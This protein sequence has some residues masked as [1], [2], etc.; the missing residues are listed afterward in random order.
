M[1]SS[2]L[3]PDPEQLRISIRE[4]AYP[5][6]Q[7]EKDAVTAVDRAVFD[8]VRVYEDHIV[9]AA[10]AFLDEQSVHLMAAEEICEQLPEQ[11]TYALDKRGATADAATAGR[12]KDLRSAAYS[13]IDA[14]R[15]SER[16]AAWHQAKAEDPYG[17]YVDMTRKYPMLRP[18]I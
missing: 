14:L 2:A 3:S 1:S 5:N 18:S 12:L 13:A 6:T 17:S 11:V 16:E 7:S 10:E 9:A 4:A 15:R 8:K